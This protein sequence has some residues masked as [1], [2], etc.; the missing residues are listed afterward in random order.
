VLKILYTEAYKLKGSKMLWLI[1]LGAFV[2]A[3]LNFIIAVEES[4]GNTL[5]WDRILYNNITMLSLILV[6]FLSSLYIGFIIAREFQ[7]NTINTL[8]TYPFSKVKFYLAKILILVPIIFCIFILSFAFVILFGYFINHETLTIE[9]IILY[10]K[11]YLIAAAATIA[12]VP[13]AATVSYIGKTYIPSMV[14]GVVIVISS[15]VIIGSEFNDEYPFT[16][17]LLLVVKFIGMNGYEVINVQHGIVSLSL[18]FLI[19]FFFNIWYINR[20]DIHSG[21]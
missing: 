19:P 2:P 9:L 15:M 20:N 14:L 11:G 3:F 13:L 6:P 18:L 10:G 4:N 21:S 1:L 17:P 16:V 7:E 8:Y 5:N 12:F